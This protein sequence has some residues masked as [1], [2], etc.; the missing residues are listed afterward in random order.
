[1]TSVGSSFCVENPSILDNLFFHL[2]YLRTLDLSFT[3]VQVVPESIANFQQL[4]YLALNKTSIHRLPESMCSLYNLQI[5]ELG[6]FTYLS[7][8]PA[9][10]KNL[11]KLQHLDVWKESGFVFMPYGIEQ[12]TALQ[13][14]Q[15]FMVGRDVQHCGMRELKHLIN[16]RGSLC[17][18]ELG[19]VTS[20][21]EAKEAGLRM[22]KYLRTLVL[23]WCEGDFK[24]DRKCINCLQGTAESPTLQWP[25]TAGFS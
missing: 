12:L 22:M 17:I 10:V 25:R 16:L 18:G 15:A 5:L 4:C 23:H 20:D 11:T 19:N 21:K 3:I 13:T 14:L 7:E 9:C 1:M 8:L 2:R 24:S 6:G